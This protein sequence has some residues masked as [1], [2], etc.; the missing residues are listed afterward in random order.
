MRQHRAIKQKYPDAILLFRVGDFYETFDQDALIASEVLN[1]TLTR[2]N[3]QQENSQLLA[4]FPYH[5]LD[6]YL[7]RLARAGYRIAICE[8]ME[9]SKNQKGIVERQ[10]TE[11]ITPGTAVYDRILS[12]Q[13]N[14]FLAAV[15]SI[16][17]ML[18]IALADL[19]TGDFFVAQGD[20]EYIDKLIR[21]FEPAEILLAK[22]FRAEFQEHITDKQC[23]YA[24]DNWVVDYPYAHQLLIDTFQTNTLKGFG[25]D[26]MP[27]AITAAGCIL[28][29]LKETQHP[30]ARHFNRLRRIDKHNSLWMD[31]FTI[32]NLEIL[33]GNYNDKDSLFNVLNTTLTPMGA[34]LL[35]NW[36]VFP[37]NTQDG[38][39]ARHDAVDFFV[40]HV[41]VVDKCKPHLQQCGDIERLIARIALRKTTPHEV[42]KLKIACDCCAAVKEI[43]Q[44]QPL[45]D[46][47]RQL[48]EQIDDCEQIRAQI[49]RVLSS[50]TQEGKRKS[51][52][53][54]QGVHPQLDEQIHVVSQSQSQ[55]SAIQQRES[56]R[57]GIPSLKVA[58]N[59]VFGYYLEVRNTYTKRV[60]PDW[61]RKQTLTE[62]ERY[63]TD[64]LAQIEAQILQAQQAIAQLEESI[65]D[66]LLSKVDR[67][68]HRMQANAQALAQIDCL[69]NFANIAQ[70]HNYTRPRLH[71][72]GELE[73]RQSRH[74]VIEKALE[75]KT[76]YIPNDVFLDNENQQIILLTGPNMSGKSA[77]LRQIALITL[78]A[79]AGSFVPCSLA[80]IPL[81]DKIFTRV[82]ASDNLSLGESTFMVE[83]NETASIINN[84]GR[85]T[86]ILL[87][88][89]GR[90]TSTFD[91]VAI[92]SAVLEFLH[93]HPSK[94]K[95][96]FA[97][98]YRELNDLSTYLHRLKNYH[99]SYQETDTEVVFL[100]KLIPGS[101]SKSFGL[102]IAQLAGFPMSVLQRAKQFLVCLEEYQDKNTLLNVANAQHRLP[103]DS[104]QPW[105]ALDEFLQNIDTDRISAIEAL[106]KLIE[107]KKMCADHRCAHPKLLR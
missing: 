97:T 98:H 88:E 34:R 85:S 83:M 72:G 82:G 30:H 4:G 65:F 58:F 9:E 70:L 28:H 68:L 39:V 13:G 10:V 57:L 52:F 106:M 53:I 105:H 74:P 96:L 48:C 25:L 60:P 75:N 62:S 76:P 93:D 99:M 43:L 103:D 2:R 33:R 102:Y 54:S 26:Q 21:S 59:N 35:R 91:G 1:I 29:Y 81:T 15:V 73:L 69:V 14:N 67:D 5:A 92:A 44:E 71:T 7:H 46:L 23:L 40:K 17:D 61:K 38:I 56:I 90:G 64:E 55:I 16:S 37:L 11:L 89:I 36:L 63:T 31:K 51:G 100:R 19:S 50:D 24:L 6:V 78:M 77:L 18:A 80:N 79:H 20:W 66:E 22:Q 87:D 47:L 101:S 12:E 32:R 42:Y 94:P 95:T 49:G 45:P 8:Q 3:S 86:L 27:A 104:S 107:I 41:G 84:V